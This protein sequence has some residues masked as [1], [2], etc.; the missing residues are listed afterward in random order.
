MSKVEGIAQ[1]KRELN[2]DDDD[3]MISL[4]NQSFRRK[5]KHGR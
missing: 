3:I 4:Q 1:L 5:D 2:A